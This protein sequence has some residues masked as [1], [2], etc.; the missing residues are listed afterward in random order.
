MERKPV[1]SAGASN[2]KNLP[3]LASCPTAAFKHL[4]PKIRRRYRKWCTIA[5]CSHGLLSCFLSL[6]ICVRWQWS[7]SFFRCA[8]WSLQVRAHAR[9]K[10]VETTPSQGAVRAD[11][12]PRTPNQESSN[13]PAL[14][15]HRTQDQAVLKQQSNRVFIDTYYR[16]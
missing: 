10:R 9:P 1:I 3:A 8:V 4:N 11:P 16:T 12:G 2:C 5:G 7:A 6:V 13:W 15:L 14:A